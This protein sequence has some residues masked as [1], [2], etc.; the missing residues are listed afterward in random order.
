MIIA[1]IFVILAGLVFLTVIGLAGWYAIRH[2]KDYNVEL[3]PLTRAD[4]LGMPREVQARMAKAG[5]GPDDI[6]WYAGRKV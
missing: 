4:R 1:I 3:K 6:D 5:V 2:E